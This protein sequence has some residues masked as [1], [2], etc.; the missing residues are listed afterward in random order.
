MIYVRFT[1]NKYIISI[2]FKKFTSGVLTGI[3]NGMLALIG[4][5]HCT[6]I[7]PGYAI[8]FFVITFF[9]ITFAFK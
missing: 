1:A 6:F 4:R 3:Y 8:T 7:R 5:Y 2:F 9:V